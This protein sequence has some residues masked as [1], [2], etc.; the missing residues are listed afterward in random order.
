MERLADAPRPY[1]RQHL[2]DGDVLFDLW[3]NGRD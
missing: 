2:L 3:L 1:C